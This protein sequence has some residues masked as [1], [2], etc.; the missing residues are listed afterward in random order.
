MVLPLSY[1]SAA[2]RRLRRFAHLSAYRHSHHTPKQGLCV[3][4]KSE[5]GNVRS[6]EITQPKNPVSQF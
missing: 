1:A 4:Q 5:S 6:A 3:A 2:F